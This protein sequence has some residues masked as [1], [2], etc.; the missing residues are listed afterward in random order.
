MELLPSNIRIDADLTL[1]A[2]RTGGVN[3]PNLD[4]RLFR[5]R[6]TIERDAIYPPAFRTLC[7]VGYKL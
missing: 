2:C 4:H 1:A 6:R 7:G 3:Y 5:F